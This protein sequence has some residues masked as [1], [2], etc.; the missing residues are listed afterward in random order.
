MY[1]IIDVTSY[2]SAYRMEGFVYQLALQVA[3][4]W[5][6]SIFPIQAHFR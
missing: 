3:E 5:S 2:V 1:H 4:R 6:E